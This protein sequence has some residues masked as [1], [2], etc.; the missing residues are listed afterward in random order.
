MHASSSGQGPAFLIVILCWISSPFLVQLAWFKGIICF[1]F[2]R[3]WSV[4]L[5]PGTQAAA[6]PQ[7][8]AFRRQPGNLHFRGLPQGFKCG[9]SE[10]ARPGLSFLPSTSFQR[11]SCQTQTQATRLFQVSCRQ[12]GLERSTLF[13]GKSK[14]EDPAQPAE[15]PGEASGRASSGETLSAWIIDERGEV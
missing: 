10:K 4:V 6:H 1:L 5:A 3:G 2:L 14:P 7:S 9:I 11:S 15:S 13:S 12:K 8:Q